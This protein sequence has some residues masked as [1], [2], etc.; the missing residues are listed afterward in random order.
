MNWIEQMNPTAQFVLFSAMKVVLV[1][2]VMLAMVVGAV[3]LTAIA[4][5]NALLLL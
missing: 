4:A 2:V 3:T 1:V 5:A